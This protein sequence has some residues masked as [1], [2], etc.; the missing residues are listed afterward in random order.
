MTKETSQEG[1]LLAMVSIIAIVA[2]VVLVTMSEKNVSTSYDLF[3]Q[4]DITGQFYLPP[5][6]G[7]IA[8]AGIRGGITRPIIRSINYTWPTNRT[9][10]TVPVPIAPGSIAINATMNYTICNET[11]P[12][13]APLIPGTT[14]ALPPFSQYRDR[15][16]A[17]RILR[18]YY[19]V[20]AGVSTWTV[21]QKDYICP[22]NCRYSAGQGTC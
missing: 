20:P 6:S 2:L 17:S 5:L 10:I 12:G 4:E 15:C 22:S 19:C 11:D 9:N 7:P 21:F 18:E 14:T 13:D 3:A 16:M 1:I 8:T